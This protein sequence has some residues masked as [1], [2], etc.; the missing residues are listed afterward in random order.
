MCLYSEKASWAKPLISHRCW[1]TI[2]YLVDGTWRG[3]ESH[4]NE[5]FKINPDGVL[6]LHDNGIRAYVQNTAI[7]I[8]I[9]LDLK[10]TVN[11]YFLMRF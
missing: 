3:D 11:P 9:L 7:G 10:I 6:E 5:D 8:S 4:N 1:A 2:K